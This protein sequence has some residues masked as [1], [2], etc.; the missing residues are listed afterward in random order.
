MAAVVERVGPPVAV[1]VRQVAASL[2]SLG[3][4]A[5]GADEINGS[6]CFHPSLVG[7]NEIAERMWWNS[8]KR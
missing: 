3:T 5:W 1:E 6:D 8:P 4:F 7:Q 2:P